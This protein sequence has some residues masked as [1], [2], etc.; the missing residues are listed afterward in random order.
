M[1]HLKD[2]PLVISIQ[3]SRGRGFCLALVLLPAPLSQL[4]TYLIHKAIPR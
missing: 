3:F 4:L 1:Q 2:Y